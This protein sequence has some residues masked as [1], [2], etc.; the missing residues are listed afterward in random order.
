MSSLSLQRAPSLALQVFAAALET[1]DTN[2]AASCFARQAILVTADGTNLHGREDIAA[3]LSQLIVCHTTVSFAELAV[4]EA[5][6]T[7][8]I[9]GI[10]SMRRKGPDPLWFTQRS[11]L[12]AVVR[13][14]EGRWK[15]TI[16]A[17]WGKPR[18][19]SEE[20]R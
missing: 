2:R 6:Q 19:G 15:F 13:E 9:S 5:E 14:I 17:P 3:L 8:L 4:I 16:L 11:D 7:A 12:T 20:L 10:C 1:A 18:P